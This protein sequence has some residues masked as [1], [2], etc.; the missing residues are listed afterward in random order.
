MKEHIIKIYNIVINY[1]IEFF[2]VLKKDV[3]RKI[4]RFKR[5]IKKF[6]LYEM[7][8]IVTVIMFFKNI[9]IFLYNK[10]NIQKY[11]DYFKN[12]TSKSFNKAKTKTADMHKSSIKF[13]NYTKG[14]IEYKKNSYKEEYSKFMTPKIL[15]KSFILIVL[16]IF[17]IYDAYSWFYHE[18]E[19][20][21][22]VINLGTIEHEVNQYSDVGNL[23]GTTSDTVTVIE[24]D[25]MGITTRKTRYIEI[26]NVGSLDLDY[27]MSFILDGTTS[28]AGVLYYRVIDI[29]DQVISSTITPTYNTKLKA[30]AAA[31]PT[32]A[33]LETDATN[34]V[35]NLTTITQLIVKGTIE[36]DNDDLE[37]NIRYYRID[38]GM[39]QT[40]NSSLYSGASVAVHT[41]VHSVQSGINDDQM[42]EG[43]IWLVENES[44]F[45]DALLNA[46]SGDTIKLVADIDVDGSAEFSRRVHL[47]T[48][49]YNLRF[50][51]DLVFDFVEVG[52]LNI[53]T[54]GGGKIDV[55]GDF[56]VSTPKSQVHF[57]GQNGTYDI[58]VGGDFTVSGIQ[59]EEEDGVLLEGVRIV[60]NKVG[61]IPVDVIV[62][63]N[64]R[65]TIAPNVEVG[66]VI[67][68]TGS[69]NIE[70]LN[71]GTITQIQLQNMNLIDS[72]SKYQIYVYNL[73]TILGV[74]GGSSIILPSNATPYTGP[75]T[76]NTLIVR[77]VS[78][79][80]I[81]VSGTPGFTGDD[82]TQGAPTDSVI[83]IQGEP[84]SY[85][86]FI[87][88]NNESLQGLLTNYF[89]SLDPATTTQEINNIKKLIIYTINSSYFENADFTYI[90]SSNMPN[91]EYLGLANATIVDGVSVNTIAANTLKDKTSLKTVILSKTLATV[92]ANAFENVNLGR[93]QTDGSFTFMS[94]PSTVTNIGANAFGSSKYVKFE[95]QIPPTVGSGAFDDSSNGTRFFVSPG[96]INLYRGVTNINEAFVYY[97][98]NL[99]DNNAYFLYDDGDGYGIAYYVSSI[100]IGTSLTVPNNLALNLI[101][102]PVTAI[103]FNAFRHITTATSGASITIPNTVTLIDSYAFYG[104]NVK[105][106]NLEN[107]LRINDYSFYNTR[108]TTL[109]MNNI[110]H[111]GSHAFHGVPLT[112][113]SLENINTISSYAFYNNTTLYEVNLGRVKVIGDYA[114]Y[115]CPQ[116][117][118]VWFKNTETALVNNAEQINLTVGENAVFTNWGQYLDGRLRVYVPTG[119]SQS[120][121]DYLTGYK[122]LFSANSAFIYP[123]GI[124]IGSYQHVAIPYDW[125]EYSVRSV[126]KNNALGQ[127]VTAYE[128][129]EYHGADL[130]SSYQIP[131]IIIAE[132]EITA[133]MTGSSWQSGGGYTFG[134]TITLTNM[135]SNALTDWTIKIDMPNGT[136]GFTTYTN[137]NESLDGNTLTLT[138]KQYNGN[139]AAGGSLQLSYAYNTT[140]QSI[141]ASI[142]S[143]Y[144]S[145]TPLMEII[146]IGEFAYR[147]A[148]TVS[149]Q[150]INITANNLLNIDDHGLENVSVSSM[151]AAN[152][153][154]IGD[155]GL[156]NTGINKVVFPKLNYLGDYAMSGMNTLYSAD[157]GLVKVL[158]AHAI[159]DNPNLEQLF[160]RNE[161]IENMVVDSTAL[162]NI[163]TNVN[164]RMRI[165]VPDVGTC[166][167]YYSGLLSNFSA[168]IYPVG[169]IV[170]SYINAPILY[171]IGEYAVRTIT[172]TLR[173]GSTLSGYEIIEYHGADLTSSYQIPTT[174]TVNG[175]T[176]D[177][178]SIGDNSYRHISSMSG[179]S[180]SI[181][182]DKIINIGAA[183]FKNITG[184]VSFESTSLQYLNEEAFNSSSLNNFS[185]TN[186]YHIGS[187]ALA[188][189]GKLYKI[190]LGKVAQMEVNSLYAL[191]NL[192]Q[193][194]FTPHQDTLVFNQNAITDVGSSTSDRL[195]FYVEQAAYME[196]HQQTSPR[197]LTA[198]WTQVSVQ[199]TGSG[200]NQRRTYVFEATITNNNADDVASW[201]TRL[202]LGTNGS[203]TSSTD[204]NYEVSGSYV[205][206]TNTSTNGT[207]PAGGNTKFQFT[208]RTTDRYTYTPSFSNT[209]GVHIDIS[210][211]PILISAVDAYANSFRTMYKDYFYVKGIMLG[212][213][214]SSNIPIDIGEYSVILV[215]HLDTNGDIIYGY[216]L[217][218]YHGADINNSF[219]IPTTLT[220]DSTTYP[221]IG[222]GKKAF[223]WAKM[224]GT[225][226][227][228]IVNS[229]LVYIDDYAFY[230]LAGV[231][232]L[233]TPNVDLIGD[234][235]FYN[236]KL[237][238][239]ETAK[240][241]N[242]GNYAYAVN[243]ALNYINNG[244]VASIGEGAFYGCTAVEQMFFK[245]TDADTGS[246]IMNITIGSNAFYNMG[247]LIGKRLRIYVPDGYLT[248]GST[249]Q[250]AYK[251]TLPTS[252]ASYVH[253]TGYI[254]GNYVFGTL[255]YDIGEYSIRK[256]TVTDS[257]GS[258]IT[259]W[260][261]VEYHGADKG[262]SSPALNGTVTAN[263]ETLNIVSI[264]N[265]AFYGTS[266]ISGQNWNFV[267]PNS[268]IRIDD[269]AFYQTNIT[270]IQGNQ[271]TRIGKYAFADCERLTTA[272]FSGV[273]QVDDYALYSCGIISYIDLGTGI[274]SLG[275]YSLWN[276]YQ[277]GPS[278][279]L[280][281]L[282][283]T[284]PTTA[285]S[286]LPDYERGFLG[287]WYN[288]HFTVSVPSA[289]Q[290]AFKNATPWRY[291]NFTTSNY[292]SNFLYVLDN[293]NQITI[294]SYTGSASNVIIPDTLP[295]NSV[296]YNVTSIKGN[297]FDSNTTIT[298]LTLPRYL[299]TLGDGFLSGN[300]NISALVANANSTTFT[301]SNGILFDITGR[302]LIRYPNGK[303]GTSYTVPSSVY[304]VA[305]KAFENQT[306]LTSVTFSSSIVAMGA[307]AFQGCTAVTT[308]AFSSSPPYLTGFGTFP[309]NSNMRINVPSAY[310]SQFNSST[311]FAE[312]TTYLRGV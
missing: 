260:E 65:L 182:N 287:L 59:N 224:N 39:Y 87:R 128:I 93:I 252:L 2:H 193:V 80:D 35:S 115:N 226:T 196:E 301:A 278:T 223:R 162:S 204:A 17:I 126:T 210:Y 194:F 112:Y 309:K 286:A 144:S 290:N 37:N 167:S 249:Y 142:Q 18:Y 123:V 191:N 125:G 6:Y 24:E 173:D 138:N 264:G 124:I 304:V 12:I 177:V 219:I 282:T 27:N 97:H 254:I 228:D 276:P 9:Y 281:M 56:Y 183:A 266:V 283:T 58:F 73:N 238:T 176:K 289:A 231:R 285:G 68:A 202:S 116:I 95:G 7:L 214:S 60:K 47:D 257:G 139:I 253:P 216:E 225:N 16:S 187:Y 186:L 111:I 50:T 174:L 109:T 85:Y 185:A 268:V 215:S 92:G 312:Y 296:E 310:L 262:N 136:S 76:G 170:G 74:L 155:Y 1:L 145:S 78:S 75:N 57:L 104:T 213:Y 234:Y 180:I 120:G 149:G 4:R 203:F 3:N 54:S 181:I 197:T 218:E 154:N 14:E 303:T 48:D 94:I 233:N 55:G 297:A 25:N 32:P 36:K 143:A 23:I 19:S 81:T 217:V 33:N 239:V 67:G 235:A 293:N 206:F 307:Y 15:S 5:K 137:A 270:S 265:Y 229:T 98:S 259:G 43:E 188:N 159:S 299:K 129:I 61:N 117:G 284:V 103:G 172:L 89:D 243:T 64:T 83:P 29:T 308:F 198:S 45:R 261:L 168:Y 10:L 242:L 63:S 230:N 132:P 294:T 246:N 100:S 86:V 166:L 156:Y 28:N 79:N 110:T 179:A 209:S 258:S 62:L 105:S 108:L 20:K 96:A 77:G 306:R 152:L 21:G 291:H 158:G 175:V 201:T 163:G 82:I 150:T 53:D 69:T 153:I 169:D 178:I 241:K 140:S 199:T 26:K 171:D 237:Y 141:T 44:Q 130:N 300:T 192:V 52:N 40:I 208:I 305:Y 131:D 122:R 41:S 22:T 101:S 263:G 207:I 221:V 102:K 269:Y 222:I 70:I 189:M 165:Y 49:T 118:R 99:S 274:Q 157:L 247:T 113:L 200:V 34:P 302:I 240:L 84:N 161:D 114:F 267:L 107:I 195:R 277:G 30:Y 295:V 245:S 275:A 298:T 119:S 272:I 134:G 127:P 273:V 151:T 71:N 90:A 271:I 148:S 236:N 106:M 38:Y 211:T 190:N 280:N 220:V 256:V 212:N 147:H 91:I 146:S 135:T 51:G 232:V 13:L 248:S 133:I 205:T 251:S 121:L 42:S 244:P 184:I 66:Y 311:Y 227:F 292:S 255:P 46:L 8:G 164:N 279:T 88:S 72:F 160:F 31:N 250:V 288:S 11:V